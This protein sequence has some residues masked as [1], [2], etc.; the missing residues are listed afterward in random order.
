M[1]NHL[2]I[3]GTEGDEIHNCYDKLL[4]TGEKCEMYN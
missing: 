3:A 1:I 4:K 2:Q